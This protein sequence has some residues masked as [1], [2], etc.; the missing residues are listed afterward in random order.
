MFNIRTFIFFIDDFFTG[1][2]HIQILND[3]VFRDTTHVMK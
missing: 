3:Y 2:T 1:V